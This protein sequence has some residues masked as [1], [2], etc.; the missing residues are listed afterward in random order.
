MQRFHYV[1]S[2]TAGC[3]SKQ[4]TPFS[5]LLDLVKLSK[6]AMK[7]PMCAVEKRKAQ[8]VLVLLSFRTYGD[9][10]LKA[11]FLF[12][13]QQRFPKFR[14]IVVTNKRGGQVYPLLDSRLETLV[15]DH[16]TPKWKIPFFIWRLPKAEWLFAIDD[17]RTTLLLSIL[18]RARHKTGWIQNI[19]RLYGTNGFFEWRSVPGWLMSWVRISFDVAKIR[20]PEGKYEGYVE[21]ELLEAEGA[22]R[23]LAA[24]RSQ[25][26]VR[27]TAT[28]NRRYIYCATEAGWKARQLSTA[29]WLELITELITEYPEHDMLVHGPHSL[30]E[31]VNRPD[32]VI[33]V[34][35][36]VEELF[37]TVANADLVI[38]ADSFVLHLASFYD[39]PAIGYFGPTHPVRFHPTGPRSSSIFHQ[40]DCCPCLQRR[41][42]SPC[43]RE[44]DQCVS[45]SSMSAREFI[46][47]ARIALP[48]GRV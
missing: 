20:S 26:A 6:I 32:K 27:G 42:D 44:L 43:Q 11:P 41:G 17:S 8:P 13:L 18:V 22:G 31:S 37:L 28:T 23:P 7:R 34:D 40:P 39:I 19:S 25:Y 35:Q 12:E 5:L 38:A 14:I 45:L 46:A 36:S 47:I 30:I 48:P 16:F 4:A 15:L 24:F 1:A 3:Q 10:V 2:S 9:Y 33:K 29:Q 21:L